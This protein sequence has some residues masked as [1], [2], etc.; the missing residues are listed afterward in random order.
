MSYFVA[1]EEKGDN[2]TLHV[3][4][5]IVFK[6]NK[7]LTGC[8]K[9]IPEAHWERRKGTHDQARSY[10][11][12]PETSEGPPFEAGEPP[13]SKGKRNDLGDFMRSVDGGMHG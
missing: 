4:G 6:G 12:K 13:S 10:C 2:G 9:V 1:Q 3:Q 11:T 8:K 7:R 5:Y